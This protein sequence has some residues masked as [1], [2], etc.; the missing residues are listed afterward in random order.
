MS[1]KMMGAGRILAVDNIESRL[2]KARSQG[3]EVIDF[4]R[5]NPVEV[6]K[7]L[8][9]GIGL[10]R[11]IDA[12]G[13]DATNPGADH[14]E[15]FQREQG[16]MQMQLK[17]VGPGNGKGKPGRAPSQALEWAVEA[18]AKAG[19]LSVIGVYPPA[20]Q[21]FP[22]GKAMNKNLTIK[23]GNC[24]HRRYVPD[25]VARVRTGEIDPTEVLTK[26]EPLMSA[27]DAYQAFD[28][29]Q[30]GWLKVEL[31]PSAARAQAGR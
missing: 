9:G 19:I 10:D 28:A 30:S 27:I 23:S 21:R 13:I 15:E 14:Q 5:E 7:E 6:I 31:K 18:L 12:V 8:T 24:N 26:V 25:L 2:D 11:A 3:A 20:M 22:L 17:Q 4:D 1:S 29:R 16:D